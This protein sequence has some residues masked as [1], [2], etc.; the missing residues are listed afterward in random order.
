MRKTDYHIH[1]NYS[2]DAA[3]VTIDAY[4]AKA[5]DLELEEVC[6]TTHLE[7]DPDRRESD[8]FVMVNGKKHSSFDWTWLDHYFAELREAQQAFKNTLSVK[9]GVEVGF[10]PGQERALERILTNY[11]FDFV[12]GAIHCVNHMNISSK[13]ES[14]HF[15]QNSSLTTIR[16]DYFNTL[17]AA[18]ETGLFDSIAHVD[19]YLRYGLVHFGPAVLTVH[20]GV[21]EPIF[22]E[23]ARR[24]MGLEINTSSCRRGLKDFHPT[25]ELI[26]LAADAGIRV[27]TVGSDAHALH[28]LGDNIDAT[29]AL[30]AEFNLTN[31]IFTQRQAIPYI[32]SSF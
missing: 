23:M 5:V 6:F 10:F 15:F 2:V 25:R 3:P 13:Q 8:N 32:Y 28:E 30:L 16:R 4:C 14:T 27:F 18:I 9:A 29:L 7:I 12:L 19:L 21:I 31:H 20:R 17:R 1:P 22:S 24:G 26:G 11:P